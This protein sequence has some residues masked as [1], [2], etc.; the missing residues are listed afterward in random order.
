MLLDKTGTLTQGRMALLEWWGDESLK[1]AAAAVEQHSAH[2]IARA[3]VAGLAAQTAD[4]PAEDV[5][6]SPGGG[7]CA[8]LG[9]QRIVL[10]SVGFVRAQGVA[11]P[12][13]A[14]AAAERFCAQGLTPVL[15]A[16]AGRVR[17]VAGLGDPLRPDAARAIQALRGR[18]WRVKILSGDHPQAVASVG[19]ALGIDAADCH[20]HVA[21]EGKL[22][23]VRDELNRGPV[24]MV[25]DGVNDAAALAA[26]TVGIA[27]HGGAE[28]SLS[29]AGIYL[30][31]PGLAPIVEVLEGG[32][33]TF[34]VIR[35]GLA[36]SV[37][38]NAVAG[39][40]AL[41]GVINPIIAAI[42]MP[43]SS[44]TVLSN[45]FSGRTFVRTG[46]GACP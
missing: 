39:T 37:L 11:L 25:G 10:G 7:I 36:A 26:A 3:L 9:A 45:A 44:L 32:E 2:P 41:T 28:A 24:I 23:F 13:Q 20:G 16:A 33:R 27:V 43:L 21:P 46:V 15:V 40:L 4:E 8:R 31:R 42:L 29:A 17:A 38:Y 22:A 34:R 5:V 19:A 12:A 14:A 1:P 35:R 6:Q 18:G 30:D